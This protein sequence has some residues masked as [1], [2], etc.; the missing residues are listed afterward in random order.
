[1]FLHLKSFYHNLIARI[2]KIFGS[3]RKFSSLDLCSNIAYSV[4]F[5]FLGLRMYLH[6][7]FMR[8]KANITFYFIYE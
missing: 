6:T 5:H 3:K 4:L 8:M 2:K 1:M 7:K